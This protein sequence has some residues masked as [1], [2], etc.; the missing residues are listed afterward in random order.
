MPLHSGAAF[1]FSAKGREAMKYHYIPATDEA[2]FNRIA[3]AADQILLEHRRIAI[4][5]DIVK[6]RNAVL[7]ELSDLRYK[8]RRNIEDDKR[9]AELE[10]EARGLMQQIGELSRLNH[11]GTGTKKP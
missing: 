9:M 8:P 11:T 1:L 10:Q 4:M 3:K 6:H 5:Q 7:R 2:E